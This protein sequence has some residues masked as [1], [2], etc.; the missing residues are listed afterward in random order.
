MDI[1]MVIKSAL[2]RAGIEYAHEAKEF[3]VRFAEFDPMSRRWT[4]I[5]Q[6]RETRLD[7]ENCFR[8]FVDDATSATEHRG[9][10]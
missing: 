1:S 7:F 10:P 9:C 3:F 2:Q 8:I 6:G 5:F 4:V